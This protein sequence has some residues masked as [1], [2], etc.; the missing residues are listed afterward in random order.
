ME[1]IRRE[2]DYALRALAVLSGLADNESRS[3]RR[4]ASQDNLPEASLR[5]IL[6]RLVRAKIVASTKGNGGGFR[7]NRLPKQIPMLDILAAVQGEVLL[8]R[9]VR[10]GA[11]CRDKKYCRFNRG[12]SKIQAD[13]DHLFG[14]MTLQ[15]FL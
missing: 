1:I 11:C 4:I 13:L 8:S 3:V 15:D 12:M 9:C 7:L 2:T 6:Q 14:Q 5:K 10:D